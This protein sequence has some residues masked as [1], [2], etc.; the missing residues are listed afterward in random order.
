M[1]APGCARFDELCALVASGAAKRDEERALETHLAEG[2]P[3]CAAAYRGLS[4]VATALASVPPPEPPPAAIRAHLLAAVE[5]DARISA[6]GAAARRAADRSA[7]RSRWPLVAG[8]AVAAMLGIVLIRMDSD[9]DR[10]AA[11]HHAELTALRTT[12]ADAED[13][14]RVM[15]ARDTTAV[16]LAGLAPSPRASGRVFWNSR[17]NA[18]LLVTFDLPA[19]PAGKVYQL[20]AIQDTEPVDAG[21]FS[22][23]PRGTGALKVKALPEPTKTVK[24]FAITIEPT[25]GSPQPTGE[26]VLKGETDPL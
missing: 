11:R 3:A 4:A 13:A 19:L 15:N 24:I 1:T 12:L 16:A 6:G 23:D 2:C 17:A 10:T 25:G 21:V 9:R 8:W 5:R 18:G 20:W 14:L 7:I 22:L 26:M